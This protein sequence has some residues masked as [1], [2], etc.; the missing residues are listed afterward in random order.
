MPDVPQVSQ[1]SPQA[2]SRNSNWFPA[3]S[4]CGMGPELHLAMDRL[5]HLTVV[6][7]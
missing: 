7:P 5:D 3:I 6:R 2:V 4:H 1:L